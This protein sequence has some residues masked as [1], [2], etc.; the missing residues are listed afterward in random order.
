MNQKD[1]LSKHL[2][3]ILNDLDFL[4]VANDVKYSEESHVSHDRIND[5][6]QKP[7]KRFMKKVSWALV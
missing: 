2:C 5:I 7:I 3:N 4:P 6:D 1:H